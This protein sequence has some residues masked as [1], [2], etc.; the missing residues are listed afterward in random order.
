VQKAYRV[1]A[2]NVEGVMRVKNHLRSLPA[3]VGLGA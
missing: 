3:S 2:E 1:A